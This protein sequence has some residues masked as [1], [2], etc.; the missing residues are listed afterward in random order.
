MNEDDGILDLLLV[1]DPFARIIVAG[2]PLRSTPSVPV[3]YSYQLPRTILATTLEF[4]Q[5]T[6]E[7]PKVPYPRSIPR[8][9][10]LLVDDLRPA[11]CDLRPAT[12]SPSLV[13][14]L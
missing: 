3:P 7:L 11:T 4:R 2:I 9:P 6:N 14:Y 10:L 5:K 12:N 13:K 1:V 8:A